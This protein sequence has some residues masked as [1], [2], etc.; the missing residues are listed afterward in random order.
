M[1]NDS[2]MFSIAAMLSRAG[3]DYLNLVVRRVE[4]N[5]DGGP[6]AIS[7]VPLDFHNVELRYSR[8]FG[9]GKVIVGVGYDDRQVD[10]DSG[11]RARGF[12]T[13]QQGF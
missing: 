1:D 12:L 2:R 13:W 3:G 8:G 4:L 10:A 6:H 11:S 5:R 7:E 9:A